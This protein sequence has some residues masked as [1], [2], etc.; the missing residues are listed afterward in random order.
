MN[1]IFDDWRQRSPYYDDSHEAFSQSLRKFVEREVSP[2]VDE[3]EEAGIV[4]R[5][6]HRKAGDT[7]GVGR[8]GKLDVDAGLKL[9]AGHPRRRQV[10]RQRRIPPHAV[11]GTREQHARAGCPQVAR[12]RGDRAIDR[13]V[14]LEFLDAIEQPLRLPGAK[15]GHLDAFPV[16]IRSRNLLAKTDDAPFRN[17]NIHFPVEKGSRAVYQRPALDVGHELLDGTRVNGNVAVE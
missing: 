12:H 15:L 14:V 9:A 13:E 6:F 5:D 1:T 8:R 17:D 11:R 7:V 2:H 16:G 4:P 10:E 3:W